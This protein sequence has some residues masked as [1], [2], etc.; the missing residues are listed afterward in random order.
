[1]TETFRAPVNSEWCPGGHRVVEPPGY[2]F[3]QNDARLNQ[4]VYPSGSGRSRFFSG[5]T[6][7]ISAID[8]PG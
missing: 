5:F 7:G 4:F 8:K 6:E 3:A 1:M 2:G